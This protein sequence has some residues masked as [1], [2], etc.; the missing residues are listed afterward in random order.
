KQGRWP[1]F[2]RISQTGFVRRLRQSKMFQF[3]EATTQTIADDSQRVG[4]GHMTK[5]HCDKLCPTGKSARMSFGFSVLYQGTKFRA[6]VMIQ[7]KKTTPWGTG[8]RSAITK[9]GEPAEAA[10]WIFCMAHHWE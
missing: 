6:R 9:A 7:L 4:V 1:I 8:A 10:Y 5:Q 3:T 2:I